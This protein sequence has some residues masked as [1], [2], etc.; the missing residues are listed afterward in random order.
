MEEGE[1]MKGEE[2]RLTVKQRFL[3][4]AGSFVRQ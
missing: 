3:I 4:R 1:Q 2:M